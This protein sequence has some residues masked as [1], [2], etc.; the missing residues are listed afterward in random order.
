MIAI[1]SVSK[2]LICRFNFAIASLSF[3][4]S[5]IVSDLDEKILNLEKDKRNMPLFNRY[6]IAFEDGSVIT[7]D[8][9]EDFILVK[10]ITEE[11]FR[12]SIFACNSLEFNNANHND[13]IEIFE[14]VKRQD[15]I[16]R[17][18]NYENG[19][20]KQLCEKRFLEEYKVY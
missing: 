9:E 20:A 3:S 11:E 8:L 10:K 17:K 4:F 6:K 12:N 13:R 19:P 16:Y 1:I 18:H 14:I 7:I 15:G 2:F 5:V